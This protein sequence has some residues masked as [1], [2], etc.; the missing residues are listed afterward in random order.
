MEV[1]RDALQGDLLPANV[2]LAGAVQQPAQLPRPTSL[3]MR[4]REAGGSL[5]GLENPMATAEFPF[6]IS[7]IAPTSS[8]PEELRPHHHDTQDDGPTSPRI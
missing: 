4:P 8:F 3:S 2:M 7:P 5:A 1:A 6:S